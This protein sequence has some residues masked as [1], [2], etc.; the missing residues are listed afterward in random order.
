MG[1]TEGT[2]EPG[3]SVETTRGA[4]VSREQLQRDYETAGGLRKLGVMYGI[5]YQKARQ[6]LADAGIEVNKRGSNGAH[7][8]EKWYESQRRSR[9][10]NPD[11][12]RAALD[13]GRANRWRDPEQRRR[14][15]ERMRANWDNPEWRAKHA[16]TLRRMWDDPAKS[17]MEFWKD[18]AHRERQRQNW[19]RRI[20]AARGRGG[21]PPGEASLHDALLRASISFTANAV[22]AGGWYIADVMIHQRPLII[23]ADGTSH[24]MEGAAEHDAARTAALEAAGFTVARFSYRQ[25]QDDADGCIASLGLSAEENPVQEIRSHASAMAECRWMRDR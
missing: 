14:Q 15:S 1:N 16:E 17:L 12:L 2:P 4:S 6:M 22:V 5:G 18:P 9:E 10:R 19:L 3:D 11:E 13:K 20:E 23:E 8:S 25:L 7:H 24:R 21:V